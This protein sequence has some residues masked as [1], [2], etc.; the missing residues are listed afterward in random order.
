MDATTNYSAFGYI[1]N[2]ATLEPGDVPISR[3]KKYVV[4]NWYMVD[5]AYNP[6][7]TRDDYLNGNHS[8]NEISLHISGKVAITPVHTMT[9]TYYTRGHCTVDCLYELG[10][11]KEEVIEP[12]VVFGIDPFDNLDNTPVLPDVSVLRWS[13]GSV[14]EPP[15]KFFLADGS[16]SKNGT[17]YSTVGAYTLSS[18]NI[19][20]VSDCLGFVFN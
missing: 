11:V 13:A 4:G 2:K 12:T 6:N 20:V 16:F 1:I 8:Y 10:M 5:H 14:I 17:V 3:T 15:V 18:G 7:L 9:P 19:E